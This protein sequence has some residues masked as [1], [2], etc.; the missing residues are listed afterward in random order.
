MRIEFEPAERAIWIDLLAL[1]AK[2]NGHIRANEETA[3]PIKQLAGMLLL[4]EDLL[5][6]TIDKFTEK[7]KLTKNSNGTLYIT[8]WEKYTLTASHR[9]VLKHRALKKEE[10]EEEDEDVTPSV[11]GVTQPVNQIKSNQIKS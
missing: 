2:D 11:T 10:S 4:P 8:K 6:K 7:G 1:A 3:Y 9:R 5:S